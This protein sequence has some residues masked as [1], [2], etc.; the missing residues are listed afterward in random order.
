MTPKLWIAAVAA[1]AIAIGCALPG[2][3]AGA[4]VKAQ[5]PMQEIG[6]G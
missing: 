2:P 1:V 4:R 6:Q 3:H 5:I